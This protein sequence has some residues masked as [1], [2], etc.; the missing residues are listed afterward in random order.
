FRR[1]PK[2]SMK[3]AQLPTDSIPLR[4]SAGSAP[5]V[6]LLTNNTKIVCLPGVPK[7]M[8]VIFSKE[9][10]PLFA[11]AKNDYFREESWL[12]LEGISESKLAPS[13]AKFSKIFSPEIYIKS[14][15]V[16]FR[17]GKSIIRIQIIGKGCEIEEIKK[18]IRAASK[19]LES[20]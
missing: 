14:H 5:G 12:G 19:A 18:K 7:E 15:P 11:N 4:N 9:V 13:L 10:K 20:T 3:M 2:A 1:P 6:L 16:G 17:K 8:K